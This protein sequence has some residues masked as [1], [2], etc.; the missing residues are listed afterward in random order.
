MV[1]AAAA[2]A[3]AWQLLAE[4]PDPELPAVSVVDLGIVRSVQYEHER[5]V[6]TVTPTYSGCPALDQIIESIR[7]RLVGAC[8][9]VEV[10]V[11]LAPAWSSRD[12]TAAGRQK[13][14][15]AGIA[16]PADF[17]TRSGGDGRAPA[18]VSLPAPVPLPALL[19][20]GRPEQCPRCSSTVVEELSAFGSTP[21]TAMW[22]CTLCREPF[23]YVKAH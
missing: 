17:G 1:T 20:P 3:A 9:E 6:V 18:P 4:V 11:A 5:L 16:P 14:S 12:I 2:T 13:L 8:Q 19:P 22:R 7:A 21:C 15:H 10:R 23:G